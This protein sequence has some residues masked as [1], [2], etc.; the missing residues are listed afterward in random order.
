MALTHIPA[1]PGAHIGEQIA[2]DFL[3]RELAGSR[4]V[5]L[6]NY[7]HPAGN[8][9]EE[10][11]LLL[12]NERGVWL[13][14]VKH[15]FGRIDAD[16][17]H[18]LHSSHRSPSPVGVI[19]S[20]AKSVSSTLQSA[21]LTNISVVGLVVLTRH[22]ARFGTEPPEHHRRKVFRLTRP[23]IDALTGTEYRYRPSNHD[24]TPTQIQHVAD[25]LVRRKVDP[26]RRIV[27][28]YRVMR[29]LEPGEGFRAYEGQ[30]IR[31]PGRRSRVKQY[32]ITG[33][34]TKAEFDAAV[35]RFEQDMRALSYL[36]GHPQIVRAI[37]FVAD[38][39]SDDTQWLLLEWIEGQSLRDRLD[40]DIPLDYQ[41]QLRIL[42]SA[43]RVLTACHEQG[44]IHRNL[45]PASI[46]LADDGSVKLGDFDFARV[47]G[48]QTIA[49]T[50]KPLTLNKYTAQELRS[51][52][53]PADERSDLYSLGAIWYD[54]ALRRPADEPV[55]LTSIEQ[56]PLPQDA[57][58]ILRLLLAPQ[59]HKRPG[60]ARE[61]SDWLELLAAA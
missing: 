58:D 22:E 53:K 40:D 26:E 27:Q 10:I 5:L 56:A 13:L 19:E 21:G 38:P 3:A 23:L 41:E 2:R 61:V 54:M 4:G 50:G 57:R 20:K 15:W 43:A 18:W 39:D 42:R 24:L 17:V 29:E 37:D 14:E 55:M 6:T 46:Y 33:F 36:D 34:A 16:Q 9:T 44:V 7:H 1:A 47:A 45:T 32:Q 59:P 60:S 25:L 52:F 48:G 28:S 31:F 51:G 49:I 30:H 12:I 8:G 11:D 35:S